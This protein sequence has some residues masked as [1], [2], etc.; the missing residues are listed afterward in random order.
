MIADYL[1]RTERT[2]AALVAFATSYADQNARDHAQ[3]AEAIATGTVEA[4]E[5]AGRAEAQQSRGYYRVRFVL[6]P[7]NR[8]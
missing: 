8:R 3:L 7:E 5:A 1:G 6:I 4:H 2:D